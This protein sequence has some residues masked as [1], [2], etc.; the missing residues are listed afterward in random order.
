MLQKRL[1]KTKI[2]FKGGIMS[3]SFQGSEIITLQ[4]GSN[5]SRT[6]TFAAASSAA[7][8]DGSIP[9]NTTISEADVKAFDETGSDKTSEIVAAESNTSLVV[10]IKLK[11]PTSGEG[12]YSLEILLTFSN[13]ETEEY[14]FTRVYAEDITA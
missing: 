10:T 9:Y 11:Y 12:R 13:A 4:P 7:A 8:N 6:F 1:G 3:D 2:L 14:D 5:L